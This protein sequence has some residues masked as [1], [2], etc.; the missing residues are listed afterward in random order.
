M[1]K[2][3]NESKNVIAY[4]AAAKGNTLL[5]Y[6][7]IK[8]DLISNVIDKAKSKQGRYLPGSHIPILDI[9]MIKKNK[10]DIIIILAWNLVDEIKTELSEFKDIEFYIAIPKLTKIK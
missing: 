2:S 10:P 4:G 8:S 5:N 7:G 9:N 6:C 1:V 3:K